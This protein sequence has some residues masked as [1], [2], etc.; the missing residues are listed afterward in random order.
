MQ[1]LVLS[2]SIPFSP[3]INSISQKFINVEYHV[4]DAL[5]LQAKRYIK[6]ASKSVLADIVLQ[7]EVNKL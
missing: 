3:L 6:N 2:P 4:T 5:V 1:M 7:K